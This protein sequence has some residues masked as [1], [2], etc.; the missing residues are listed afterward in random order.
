MKQ[1]NL[2]LISVRINPDVL[3]EID[4]MA[5]MHEY[6]KRNAIINN[7]LETIFNCFTAEEIY[8]MV[9]RSYHPCSSIEAKFKIGPIYKEQDLSTNSDALIEFLKDDK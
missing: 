9:R 3:R 4:Y 6:W 7:L 8:D 5:L 1:S 2:K